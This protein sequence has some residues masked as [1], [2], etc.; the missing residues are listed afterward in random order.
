MKPFAI[1]VTTIFVLTSSCIKDDN[2]V[3]EIIN[4]IQVN[5]TVPAFTV[6]DGKGGSF[7]SNEFTGKSSI[8]I[9]FSTTC[10]DC[11]RELPVIEKVWQNLKDDPEYRVITIS[12]EQDL[13][14]ID[15]Y[16]KK[17]KLT[18]PKYLDPDRTV[19]SMFANSTIPRVYIIN[20]HGVVRWMAV[21]KVN[22]TAKELIEKIRTQKE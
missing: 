20:P 3:D 1:F 10:K 19:F 11:Q 9:L 12:R 7:N 4:Y 18:M 2:S 13:K 21:E 5:D 8:L 16:W 17:K 14:T 15:D 6:S 22:L